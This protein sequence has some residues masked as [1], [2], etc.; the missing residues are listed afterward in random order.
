MERPFSYGESNDMYR[1]CVEFK[2]Y[3]LNQ[4]FNRQYISCQTISE[5]KL[6]SVRYTW[7]QAHSIFQQAKQVQRNFCFLINPSLIQ[8]F[9]RSSLKGYYFLLFLMKKPAIR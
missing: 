3:F 9:P 2:A 8:D 5:M 6:F 7:N 1:I 4:L